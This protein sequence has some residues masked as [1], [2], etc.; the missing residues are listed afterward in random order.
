[1][2]ITSTPLRISFLGGGTDY[3]EHFSKHGGAT[4]GTSIDRSTFITVTPLTRFFDHRLRVSYSRTELCREIDEIQHPSV[5]ECLRFLGIHEGVEISVV[6]D[7]PARTGL[8]SSSSFTVG[9]LLA[10]HAFK[11]ELVSKEQLAAEAV[12]VERDMIHERVGLQDQYT[13]AV[14]GFLHLQ[15]RGRD[16]V[17]LTS[18]PLLRTRCDAL[19]QRLLLFYSGQQRLAHDILEPQMAR[20]ESGDLTSHLLRLE[21]LVREG[22]HVLCSDGDLRAF[23]DLL[24][25][26]WMLKRQLSDRV[27]NQAIDAVYE[28]A[29]QAG[30]LGGKL[31][32]AGGGGFLLLYAE[33]EYHEAIRQA[34]SD[35]QEAPFEFEDQGARLVFF[36][37]S[38]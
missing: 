38:V 10:L 7:L 35:V 21:S 15:F 33:P 29:R 37:R 8:G 22:I 4:L 24:H 6:A 11:G 34:L 12:H 17:N 25:Q 9:L 20:T 2:I 32:G 5:R 16:T 13:C 31:L 18:L 30:A 36:R 23:G 3:P 1:M 27:T 14:G 28:R 19:R 26:G